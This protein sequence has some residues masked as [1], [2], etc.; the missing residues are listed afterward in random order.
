[1]KNRIEPRLTPSNSLVL[2][3]L[4]TPLLFI[5]G[6][7]LSFPTPLYHDIYT[8]ATHV[9][10][11]LT[12]RYVCYS[13]PFF[14]CADSIN[15]AVQVEAQQFI[16]KKQQEAVLQQTISAL[17]GK[18]WDQCIRDPSGELQSRES[19]CVSNCV[20]TFLISVF[21]C[22]C[23]Y[24]SISIQCVCV[25]VCEVHDACLLCSRRND[26]RVYSTAEDKYN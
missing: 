20:G 4:R 22:L 16:Q 25:C 5:C 18:C 23:V 1:M 19:K 14:F 8:T 9:T 15:Q 12:R 7:G 6:E 11:C 26:E 17:T 3:F 10:P 13:C 24:K 21:M 2:A